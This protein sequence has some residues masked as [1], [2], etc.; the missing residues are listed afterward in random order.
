MN[1]II[2][3]IFIIIFLGVLFFSLYCLFKLVFFSLE[4]GVQQSFGDVLLS[5]PPAISGENASSVFFSAILASVISVVIIIFGALWVIRK[6]GT[7][8]I[9]NP[10]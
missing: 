4:R 10:K 2:V 1:P 5:S 9:K 7:I 6:R 3:L 8:R